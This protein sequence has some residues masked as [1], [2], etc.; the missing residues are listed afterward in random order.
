MSRNKPQVEYLELSDNIKGWTQQDRTAVCT[1][2]LEIKF[3]ANSI[4][5]VATVKVSLIHSIYK[6]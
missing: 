4:Y 2:C 6:L 1:K 3:E 5:F